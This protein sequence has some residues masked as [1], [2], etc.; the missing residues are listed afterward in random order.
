[1]IHG[2]TVTSAPEPGLTDTA[3]VPH[4][5]AEPVQVTSVP[6]SSWPLYEWTISWCTAL[7]GSESDARRIVHLLHSLNLSRRNWSSCKLT[8]PER[9]VRTT[10]HGCL[11]LMRPAAVRQYISRWATASTFPT[12]V[13]LVYSASASFCMHARADRKWWICLCVNCM[14]GTA[15]RAYHCCLVAWFPLLLSWISRC[16]HPPEARGVPRIQM[17]G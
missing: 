1:M 9:W 12:Q 15:S 10:E 13:W 7:R 4:A 2:K 17:S 16:A 5:V 6:T 3:G 14:T 11:L 8:H